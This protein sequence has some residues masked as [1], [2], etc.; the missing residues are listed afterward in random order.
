MHVKL[1]QMDIEPVRGEP[2]DKIT[3]IGRR[4]ARLHP[5]NERIN[6]LSLLYLRLKQKYYRNDGRR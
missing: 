4:V 6:T 5:F 3:L 1:P 2:N